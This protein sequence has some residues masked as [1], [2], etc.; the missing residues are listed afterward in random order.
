M[1]LQMNELQQTNRNISL[2]LES[3]TSNDRMYNLNVSSSSNVVAAET[4]KI[5]ML[6]ISTLNADKQKFKDD[7]LSLQNKLFESK[8]SNEKLTERC[9]HAEVLSRKATHGGNF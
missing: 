6:Q 2:R 7:N 4:N 3:S 5:L 9:R 1:Q 8:S